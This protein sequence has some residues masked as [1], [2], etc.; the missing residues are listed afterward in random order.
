MAS[1]NGNQASVPHLK[2]DK[3]GYRQKIDNVE[4]KFQGKAPDNAALF[5]LLK[6]VMEEL[7]EIKLMLKGGGRF[8]A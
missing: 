3:P 2:I 6:H 8:G 1:Q 7:H 5:E 4:S